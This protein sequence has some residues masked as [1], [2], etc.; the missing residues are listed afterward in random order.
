MNTLHV[1]PDIV[2]HQI[3]FADAVP[4]FK[5]IDH[6]REQLRTWL[7][8]VDSTKSTEHT[9]AFIGSLTNPHSRELVFTIRYKKD[10]AG[11]IGFKDID[12]NNKKLEIGY[13][14]APRFEGRG[15]MIQSVKT[16]IATAFEKMQMNRIQIKCAVGNQ[17]SSKIPKRL[18]FSLEGIERQGENLNG[19]FVDLEVYSL[20]K[21]DRNENTEKTVNG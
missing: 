7:P 5:L 3:S 6:N 13:W 11:L 19:R 4:V 1:S 10:V 8:F 20:L 18:H 17:R 15:I 2:L 12:R 16:L 9:E 14:I 21:S